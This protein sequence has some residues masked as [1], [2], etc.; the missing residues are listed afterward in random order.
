MKFLRSFRLFVID[1]HSNTSHAYVSLRVL[2][3]CSIVMECS[4]FMSFSV[5][6]IK[7]LY[8]KTKKNAKYYARLRNNMTKNVR[9]VC[10]RV[11]SNGRNMAR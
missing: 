9:S 11:H 2:L 6:V 5:V 3:R 10:R 8:L 7:L 1:R 4:S